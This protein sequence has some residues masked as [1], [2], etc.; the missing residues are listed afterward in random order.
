VDDAADRLRAAAREH[1]LAERRDLI[2]ATLDCADR[3]AGA[4]T[5]GRVRELLADCL[6]ERGLLGRFPDALAG[7]VA[8][9]GYEMPAA[10]AP[11]PPYVVVTDAGVLLRATLPPG[12]LVATVEAFSVERD[13]RRY[14]RAGDSPE[15]ALVVEVR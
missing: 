7:A 1:L 2:A 5:D 6:R 4:G 10:P 12:R 13:P 11:A 15:A 9:A 8:A 14:V 3:V